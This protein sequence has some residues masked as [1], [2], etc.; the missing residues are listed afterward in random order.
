LP[1][2]ELD[3][4]SAEETGGEE[5]PTRL[6][7]PG[8]EIATPV[9]VHED[10]H[11]VQDNVDIGVT[12]ANVSPMKHGRGGRRQGS[13]QKRP[14]Q[15]PGVILKALVP[16]MSLGTL[17]P[18]T[19]SETLR[20]AV[21][22][23]PDAARPEAHNNP[24]EGIGR[25]KPSNQTLAPKRRSSDTRNSKKRKKVLPGRRKD[26]HKQGVAFPLKIWL[27]LGSHIWPTIKMRN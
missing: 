12:A 17:V 10:V 25:Q 2:S 8:S 18:V 6:E 11:E 1:G 16:A 24:A 26:R 15:M 21:L 23:S 3:L 14:L 7:M 13:D 27:F 9:W 20:L 4:S 5:I 22:G 19:R